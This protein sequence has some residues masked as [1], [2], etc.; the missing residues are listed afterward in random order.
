MKLHIYFNKLSWILS[1]LHLAAVLAVYQQHFE[2]S[3]GGFLLFLLDLPVSLLSFLPIGWNQWFFFG[4]IGSL[5]WFAI[6]IMIGRFA[7]FRRTLS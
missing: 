5:W 7:G 1:A 3:W 4:V 2:G 6:G